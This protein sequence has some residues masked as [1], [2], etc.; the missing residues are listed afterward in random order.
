MNPRKIFLFVFIFATVLAIIFGYFS[1][2]A[3]IKKPRLPVLGQIQ[4]FKLKNID[5]KDITLSSLKGRV[6]VADFFFTSCS[7]VCPMMTKQMAALNRSFELVPE[8]AL[9]SI[10]V[11]PENDS[12]EV[13]KQYAQ[14][15]KANPNWYFLTGTREDITTLAVKSFKL[16]DISE[17]IFHSTYF[18]LVDKNGLIRGY[19]DGTKQEDVNKLFKDA[20]MLIK[21][22]Y[23]GLL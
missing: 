21:E 5:Q 22:K 13:L 3:E 4:E 7:G 20:A 6:W 16:G 2:Q 23:H 12:A 1:F 8:I 17:P 10:T 18:T 11:N 19:Y 15:Q 9:V 14:K